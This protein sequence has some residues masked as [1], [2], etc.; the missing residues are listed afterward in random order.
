MADT[1]MPLTDEQHRRCAQTLFNWTWTLLTKPDRTE[2]DDEMMVHVAHGSYLHWS[3]V[4]EPVHF[5]R[6]E[7]LLSRVHAVLGRADGALR[8]ARRSLQICQADDIGPFDL[9]FAYEA[10]ARAYV[11]IS[12][13]N[14]FMDMICLYE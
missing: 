7:W 5:S 12:S 4:G 8:H 13:I 3:R 14:C 10:H 11:V 9:A 6:G 2:D 1:T